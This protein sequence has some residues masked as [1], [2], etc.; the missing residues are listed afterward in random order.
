MP[1]LGHRVFLEVASAVFILPTEQLVG[2]FPIRC[3]LGSLL[4]ESTKN[5]GGINKRFVKISSLEPS[6]LISQVLPDLRRLSVIL[7]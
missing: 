7:H 5:R 4:G 6:V 2:A 1:W 3:G